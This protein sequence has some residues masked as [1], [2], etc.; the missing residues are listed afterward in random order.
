MGSRFVEVVFCIVDD[1]GETRKQ[2]LYP[3]FRINEAQIRQIL[4]LLAA[5][6]AVAKHPN[7]LQVLQILGVPSRAFGDFRSHSQMKQASQGQ[8]KGERDGGAIA[9]NVRSVEIPPYLQS[10]WFFGGMVGAKGTGKP[11]YHF[12]MVN[13]IEPVNVMHGQ[14]VHIYGQQM[15]MMK[16][17]MNKQAIL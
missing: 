10:I 3:N 1:D 5:V 11:I 15:N 8:S 4:K 12:N 7:I 16:G 17:N 6:F 13:M 9:L 2:Q 14:Q